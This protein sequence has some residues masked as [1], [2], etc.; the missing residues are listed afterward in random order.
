MASIFTRI[1]DREIPGHFLWEDA[2]CIAIMTIQPIRDGHCMVI[3]KQEV[4]HWDDVPEDTARHLMGVCQKV[5]KAV[6]AVV[7]CRRIGVSIVGIEVPHTHIHLMPM[8]T[9]ADM[10][11][12]NAREVSGEALAANAA[13]IRDV[14]VAQG[15]TEAE[16]GLE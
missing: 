12:R 9:T 1:I 11:F 13:K 4:D 16:I 10:D 5:A 2:L 7:P 3:P 8:D 15:C 6:K 14:L